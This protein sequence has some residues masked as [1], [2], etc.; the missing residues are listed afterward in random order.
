MCVPI[1]P[2]IP[3][4]LFSL[5]LWMMDSPPVSIL[6][7]PFAR[8]GGAER[9]LM[10][11]QQPTAPQPQFRFPDEIE[12]LTLSALF[13]LSHR[14]SASS[15]TSSSSNRPQPPM[16][17]PL[18]TE[19]H[20]RRSIAN[21][22][23]MNHPSMATTTNHNNNNNSNHNS[24]ASSTSLEAPP[25]PPA[26][27]LM[28]Q[29]AAAAISSSSA[30][31]FVRQKLPSQ[32]LDLFPTPSTR[33]PLTEQLV[34]MPS[35]ARRP[36]LGRD[37]TATGVLPSAPSSTSRAGLS[38][39]ARPTHGVKVHPF[40]EDPVDDTVS[41]RPQLLS[42]LTEFDDPFPKRQRKPRR[43]IPI[44]VEDMWD[45]SWNI[46]Q[47]PSQQHRPP[48]DL[49]LPSSPLN[50]A[51]NNNSNST[52]MHVEKLWNE[53]SR[54]QQPFSGE[55]FGFSHSARTRPAPPPQG[56]ANAEERRP[57]PRMQSASCEF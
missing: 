24:V 16:P 37:R 6:P 41:L 39:L 1:Q 49:S 33:S 25:P 7:R 29:P 42:T 14:T 20:H 9:R 27:T 48:K 23:Q 38:F 31:P 21:E 53:P 52:L 44:I 47:P 12:G 8:A 50:N 4:F 35:S 30:R 45:S 32:A 40:A 17:L 13:S 56:L 2:L 43:N 3:N 22:F 28:N 51:S 11:Q 55:R 15:S 34:V 46:Q 36:T 18:R 10:Q 54:P 57:Y 26:P 19:G 5:S